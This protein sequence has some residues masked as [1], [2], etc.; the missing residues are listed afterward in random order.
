MMSVSR[1]DTYAGDDFNVFVVI[2]FKSLD[3]AKLLSV[4]LLIALHLSVMQRD[5]P[6]CAADNSFIMGRE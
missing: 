2:I 3:S 6:P 4:L 5:N 1:N